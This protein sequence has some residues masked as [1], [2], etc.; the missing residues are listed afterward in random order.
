MVR[1]LL[2]RGMLVGLLAGLAAFGFARWKGEPS[3]DKAIAIESYLAA[4]EPAEAGGHSHDPVSRAVQGTAGLGTGAIIFGVAMGGLF[5]LVFSV[6]YG[7][8]GLRTAR[9]TAA[10]LG[11][12]AF[13]G[14]YVVPWLKYPPNPPAVGLEDTIGRRTGLYLTMILLSVAAMVVAAVVRRRL[15]PRFGAWNATLVVGA[16]YVVAMGIC[17]AA[18]PGVNEVPQLAIPGVIDGVADAVLT[19]PSSVV[20]D[21]R[22]AS[23]GV[24]AVTWTVIAVAFG[25][26]AERLLETDRVRLSSRSASPSST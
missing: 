23:L 13:V 26:L 11:V 25:P 7:R 2:I 6:A 20:W 17:F 24:Q 1:S 8:L 10:A 14:V 21:F 18:L 4:Q 9:G 15:V 19:F 12:L 5:A 3:V 16:G 22:I